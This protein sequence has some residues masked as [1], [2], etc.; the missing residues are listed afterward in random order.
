M[1]KKPVLL[2]DVDGV[3]ADFIELYLRIVHHR[4]PELRHTGHDD[5]VEWDCGRALHLSTDELALVHED[6]FAPGAASSMVPYAGAVYGVEQLMK[7]ADVWFV[8]SPMAQSAT[9]MHERTRWIEH[10]FGQQAKSQVIH[11]EKK[12]LVSGD[13]FVDDKPSHVAAWKNRWTNGVGTLW[14]RAYNSRECKEADTCTTSWETLK[15][16]VEERSHD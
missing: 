16:I 8:T 14:V 4:I 11:A 7:V 13:I 10:Y 2:L 1:T 5:I 15:T 9:W 12:F 3:I 6:L